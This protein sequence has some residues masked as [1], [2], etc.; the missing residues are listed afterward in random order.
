MNKEK[1]TEKKNNMNTQTNEEEEAKL[2]LIRFEKLKSLKEAEAKKG[3]L[4]ISTFSKD[5]PYKWK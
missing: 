5:I 4:C 2:N 3:N 1:I